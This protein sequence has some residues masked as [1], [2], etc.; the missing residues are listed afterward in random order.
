MKDLDA[1]RAARREALGEA[2]VIRFGGQDFVL[3]IE[4]PYDVPES[5]AAVARATEAGDD[6]GI[7]AG[8][9]D[10]LVALLGDEQYVAFRALRPSMPDVQEFISAA[11]GEYGLKLGEPSASE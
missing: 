3:D 1:V 7:T 5:L 11:V 8:V 9:K 6:F 10:T 2:P 4:L